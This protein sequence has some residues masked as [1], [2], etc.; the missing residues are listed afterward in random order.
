GARVLE[1]GAGSGAMTCAL[2][3]A[4]GDHGTVTSYEIRDD[5]AETATA[6]VTNFFGSQPSGWTLHRGDAT[7]HDAPV[8]RVVLDML[9]P[10]TMIDTVS[11][12]LVPGGVLAVYVAT[13]TQLSQVVEDL[14][15]HGS[16]TEPEAWETL[17]RPWH[18]VG[19]AVR[20]NHRMIAHTA[21]VM[22]A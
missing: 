9:E 20:P 18:V 11:R 13:T 8:D 12:C 5:H 17:H 16:F 21:F 2:L 14:R 4:V 10:S 1:A 3:R 6:N 7:V 22:T 19:L 15:D